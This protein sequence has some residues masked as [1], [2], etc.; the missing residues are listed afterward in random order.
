[1]A[2]TIGPDMIVQ[3]PTTANFDHPSMMGSPLD[4]APSRASPL[5]SPQASPRV[6]PPPNPPF[7]FPMRPLSSSPPSSFSR[8]T[9]R[10]PRSVVEDHD[11]TDTPEPAE[12]QQSRMPALPAF[13]FNPGAALGPPRRWRARF[14]APSVARIAAVSTANTTANRNAWAQTRRK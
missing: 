5:P 2:T 11:Q 14:S 4:E 8:A 3:T 6:C 7:V 10:R 12:S 1:M 13:S 9:G